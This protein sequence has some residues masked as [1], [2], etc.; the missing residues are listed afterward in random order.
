MEAPFRAPLRKELGQTLTDLAELK[1][2]EMM[3]MFT[4]IVLD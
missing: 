2:K 3:M 1:R 4:H